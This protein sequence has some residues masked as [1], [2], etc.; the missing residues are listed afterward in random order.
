MAGSIA[1]TRPGTYTEHERSAAPRS[2]VPGGY[3]CETSAMWDGRQ[4]SLSPLADDEIA[5]SKSF[6]GLGID[7]HRRQIADV[8]ALSRLGGGSEG[9]LSFAPCSPRS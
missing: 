3:E 6:A 7:R 8:R 2:T 1:A 5:S 9:R 4:R